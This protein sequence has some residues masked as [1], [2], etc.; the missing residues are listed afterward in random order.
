M[1]HGLLLILAAIILIALFIQYHRPHFRAER[2]W[3]ESALLQYSNLHLFT[4]TLSEISNLEDMAEKMLQRTLQAFASGEGCLLLEAPAAGELQSATVQGISKR[5]QGPLSSEPLRSYLTGSAQRWGTQMVFSDLRQAGTIAGCRGDPVFQQ[6]Q[7]LMLS[8]GLETLVVECLQYKG[9]SYGALL[10]GSRESRTFQPGELR[11]LS[12]IGHQISAS[13]ENRF[14]HQAAE[15]HHEELKTLHHIGEAL[16]ATFDPEAQIRTLQ[17]ELRGLLGSKNFSLAFQDSASGEI[18]TTLA[19][20]NPSVDPT[21]AGMGLLEHVLRTRTPLLLVYNLQGRAQRLGIMAVDERIRTWCGV[22][23]R[24]SDGSVGV[25]AIADF[26]HE[27]ALDEKQFKFVQVLAGG[28]AVAIENARLFQ[29]EQRRARHLALLNE[30][31]Q[32]AAAVLDPQELLS[33]IGRQIHDAFGFEFVRLEAVDREQKELVVQAQEGY[34][35]EVLGRRSKLG[36]G[37]AGVAAESGEPVL[38]NRVSDDQCY[39]ALDTRVAS[40]LSLPLKFRGETLGVLSVESRRANGFSPQDSVTLRMLA[41]QLAIALHNAR[42]YQVAQEQAITDGLT[43]LKTHRYFREALEAEWRRAAR[44]GQPLSVIMMDLDDFKLVND[45]HGHVEGDKVLHTVARLLETRL[46]Q[47]S[48]AAR[49]GGDEFVLLMPDAGEEQA[50]NLAERLRS[51]LVSDPYLSGHSLTAS[52]GIAT[53]PLHGATPEEILRIADSGMYLAKH[54]RGDQIRLAATAQPSEHVEAYLGVA[55]HRMISTGPE[56]FEH[57]FRRIEQATQNSMEEGVSLLDTV[58]ALAFVIDAKDR[59]TQGHSQ[60]VARLAAGI[61]RQLGMPEAE[62]EE[63]RLAGILHD[64]GKIGIPETLLNKPARLTADEYE[65]MKGHTELGWKILM[66]L[67][68]RAIER[69]CQMVRHHH[70][71]IDGQG[72]PDGL[73]GE[74]IPL[75]ARILT[76]ADAYDTIISDRA[77]Q[78]ARPIDEAILELRRGSGAHFDQGLVDLFVQSHGLLTPLGNGLPASE[79]IQ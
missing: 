74:E 50:E 21:L 59:Y 56:T 13:L 5:A 3:S 11:L 72:Y 9:K 43:G 51:R 48:V 20:E 61:A 75:G 53:F 76:I 45:R 42:A 52:F 77:Y 26:E 30:L 63:V 67:K 16:S 78:A 58:T 39:I 24:F 22:P 55:M 46:R 57:Y 18:E 12:A 15:R 4:V 70:E 44:S 29:K 17:V 6:F 28:I 7:S 32:K 69:I 14:L 25:L 34:G 79:T 35:S 37:L 49:Y 71:R 31:G 73:K 33:N 10:V 27:Y 1:S 41:D 54:A 38:A 36:E 64:I 40:A 47:S 23:L 60:S 2:A 62:V 68:V 66:P 8:E 65:V 19:F